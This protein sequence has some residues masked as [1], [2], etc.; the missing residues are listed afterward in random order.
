MLRKNQ[1]RASKSNPLYG[2]ARWISS[3]NLLDRL[4]II[5]ALAGLHIR[6][7]IFH[8]V[9]SRSFQIGRRSCFGEDAIY[10]ITTYSP[11]L[12]SFAQIFYLLFLN[13]IPL[14]LLIYRRRDVV[15]DF[16][17]VILPWVA[18]SIHIKHH[19]S[20]HRAQRTEQTKVQ[21]R[22]QN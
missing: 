21:G 19:S 17:S 14:S 4:G 16:Y 11:G 22:V 15:M 13:S 12:C 10:K 6:R 5:E 8:F 18:H 9:H 2:S 1:C 7:W 3:I 20:S